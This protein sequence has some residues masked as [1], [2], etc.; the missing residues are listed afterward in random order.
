MT[1][2][3]LPCGAMFSLRS[4]FLLPARDMTGIPPTLVDEEKEELAFNMGGNCSPPL[5]VAVDGLE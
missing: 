3:K 4:L 1:A 5:L 2:L